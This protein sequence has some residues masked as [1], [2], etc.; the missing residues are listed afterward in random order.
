MLKVLFS[1][2]NSISSFSGLMSSN[3]R[4]VFVNNIAQSLEEF[5]LRAGIRK[6]YLI[7][8]EKGEAKRVST[9]HLFIFAEVFNVGP[10]DLVKN[11]D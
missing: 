3:S 2:V 10:A 7:K 11:I 1:I 8:I 5:F 4:I 9:K 6:Q